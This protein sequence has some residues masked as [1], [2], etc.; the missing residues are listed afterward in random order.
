MTDYSQTQPIVRWIAYDASFVVVAAGVCLSDD[1]TANV[2]L[3][4]AA[5][6]FVLNRY[7]EA[8]PGLSQIDLATGIVSPIP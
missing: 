4:P 8:T 1:V 6:G 2:A 5:V 7:A 3:Y